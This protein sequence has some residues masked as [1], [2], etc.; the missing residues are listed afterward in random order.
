MQ[1]AFVVQLGSRSEGEISG[2]VEAVDTGKSIR[3]RSGDELLTFLRRE[4]TP[5]PEGDEYH[6]PD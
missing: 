4:Q 2:R 3:F 6:L 5:T 1:G